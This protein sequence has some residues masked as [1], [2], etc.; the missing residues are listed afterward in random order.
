MGDPQPAHPREVSYQA[1]LMLRLLDD[2]K[3]K[4]TFRFGTR[5]DSWRRLVEDCRSGVVII[6]LVKK[7]VG[8]VF[9]LSKK[10]YSIILALRRK[11]WFFSII[12]VAIWQRHLRVTFR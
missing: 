3:V 4:A 7:P 6:P 12:T 1:D 8:E 5:R 10:S 11:N 2:V 9:F